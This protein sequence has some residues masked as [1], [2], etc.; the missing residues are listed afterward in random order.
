[1][2]K[3]LPVKIIIIIIS[4]FVLFVLLL[5]QI[6]ISIPQMVVKQEDIQPAELNNV[7]L[8]KKILIAA[9]NSEFKKAVIE[10]LTQSL[11]TDSI[12]IKCIGLSELNNIDI[13][14]FNATVIINKT[15]A[16]NWDYKVKKFLKSNP[17]HDNVIILT[18]SGSGEWKPRGKNHQFDAIAAASE[19]GNVD[20]VAEKIVS[21][22][23]EI[24]LSG[25]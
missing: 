18:T 7:S 19:M 3:K 1:M 25:Y 5:P 21:K 2:N 4:A 22:I 24:L 23:R 15:M 16:W 13:S 8:D 20:S 12:Y 11:K 6:G 17:K 9:R 14:P 10:K